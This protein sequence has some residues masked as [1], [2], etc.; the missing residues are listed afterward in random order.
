MNFWN[1][2]P[3]DTAG[4]GFNNV[5]VPKHRHSKFLAAFFMSSPTQGKIIKSGYN[6]S[7]SN[8]A[9]DIHTEWL[10]GGYT[11]W[12]LQI[13]KQFPQAELNTSW[14]I[15]EDVRFSFPIGKKFPLFIAHAARFREQA[16]DYAAMTGN[17]YFRGKKSCLSYYFF[18]SMNAELSKLAC[19]WMLI[20]KSLA[21]ILKG[22]FFI[23]IS[24]LSLGFG[25]LSSLGTILLSELGVANVKNALEG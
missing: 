9:D 20:G 18:V 7:I 11:L 21:L 25:H 19:F 13:L 4:V 23:N 10:G 22:C 12:K 17:L 3:L 15:G 8:A 24:M 14:A 16:E 6:V 1:R 5:G 2:A